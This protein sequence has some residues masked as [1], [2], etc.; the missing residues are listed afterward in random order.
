MKYFNL[1]LSALLFI[2]ILFAAPA[3]KEITPLTENLSPETFH[4]REEQMITFLLSRNHYQK[5]DIDDSLSVK[6]FKN[7]IESLDGNR[8]YFLKHDIDSFL[9]YRLQIDEALKS[10]DLSAAYQIFNIFLQRFHQRMDYAKSLLQN[11]FDYKVDEYFRPDREKETW[12]STSAQL[13]S[14]WRKL[15]KNEALKLK[16]AGKKDEEIN[17]TLIKRYTNYL[18]R[19][20]KSESE[21]VFQYFM[22]AFSGTFDPH[23][24]Y[25]SPKRSADF[26]I[27]MSHSL[28]G[29]GASLRIEDD[30]TK[31]VEIISGG[32]ADKSGL[33]HAN[34]RISA[35]GQGDDGE[36]VDVIGWRI[37]DVV[38]LIRGPKGTKVRLQILPADAPVGSP[39]KTIE[40]IRDKVRLADKAAKSDTL[41][42]TENGRSYKI[43]VID[44]PDFYFD[45]EAWRKGDPLYASTTKDV[46]RI[47][48]ELQSAG[49]DGIIIDL[50]GNGGGFL[51]EA[52]KLSGLFIKEGPIV[53]VK[54]SQGKIEIDI[55]KDPRIYYGGPLVVL[56]DR[57]SASA[58]EIFSAAI[59]DYGRG[60]I[61]GEQS[62]G[63]GTVQNVVPLKRFLQNNPGKYGQLKLTI[64]KF[65]RIN[66]GS[67]QN[68]G[69][70]PDI[71]FPSRWE[72]MEVGERYQK[73]AL[74]WDQIRP[75][76]FTPFSG[77]LKTILP[78]LHTK[79]LSRIQENP[80]YE[81]MQDEIRRINEDRNK[82]LLSLQESKRKA[83]LDKENERKKKYSG[84]KKQDFVLNETTHILGDLINI[85]A[86][87]L[88]TKR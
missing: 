48:R 79:H 10:G 12:A 82:N 37:D 65:Y 35:V 68:M 6:I 56:V 84:D 36:I 83:E 16:L 46:K 47:L 11:S 20:N 39:P 54:N 32:P 45:H 44:I 55:D 9:E 18:K 61:V 7:Y 40:I 17:K 15:L 74:L 62:Y 21:D 13:D 29:I 2:T 70:I 49:V 53:Q 34:D 69:V 63:K 85:N 51:N 1:F 14:I 23:T 25:M 22:N 77:D 33:L 73:Y 42:I 31:V 26:K 59:Q 28:E 78:R 38:Q 80:Q 43:G 66:G 19:I 41:E 72:A 27:Q 24:A 52:I 75:A 57:L 76:I 71:T 67:T 3:S 58:S 30:Y 50:R 64:A 87:E 8:L 60:L 81:R 88:Q 5:K 4:H 86:D